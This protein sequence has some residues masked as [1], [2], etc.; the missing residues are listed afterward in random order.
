MKSN[1]LEL[2]TGCCWPFLLSG[3]IG[4]VETKALWDDP[5]IPF[6]FLSTTHPTRVHRSDTFL[7]AGPDMYCGCHLIIYCINIT[8]YYDYLI[9]SKSSAQLR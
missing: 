9:L 8:S 1:G 3:K 6:R 4:T 7:S 2:F 5:K